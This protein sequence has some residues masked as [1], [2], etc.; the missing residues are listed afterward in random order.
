MILNLRGGF[1]KK[2]KDKWAFFVANNIISLIVLKSAS[3]V[4]YK[5]FYSLKKKRIKK[6]LKREKAWFLQNRDLFPLLVV[7]EQEKQQIKNEIL[8]I[9][10]KIKDA[11]YLKHWSLVAS[12]VRCDSRIRLSNQENINLNDRFFLTSEGREE[13]KQK[14][15]L[16]KEKQ[17]N[18]KKETENK[19]RN[20]HLFLSDEMNFHWIVIVLNQV[21][22]LSE[23][24]LFDAI[25]RPLHERN[26]R[27]MQDFEKTLKNQYLEEMKIV[28]KKA[29]N[30][31]TI[32]GIFSSI[33]VSCFFPFT[34]RIAEKELVRQL[35][36]IQY[37]WVQLDLNL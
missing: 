28:K 22:P 3:F 30:L 6:L 9:L 12:Q 32:V 21:D 33:L 37:K 19:I 18:L 34:E 35:R 16:L 25:R 8:N 4:L 11:Y 5:I 26:E 20:I 31:S 36:K 24:F 13:V 2:K 15:I 7:N 23:P 1:L 17:N 27:E 29:D 10:K 14:K